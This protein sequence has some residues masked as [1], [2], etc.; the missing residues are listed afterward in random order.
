MYLSIGRILDHNFCSLRHHVERSVQVNVDHSGELIQRV[1][2]VFSRVV[3]SLGDAN[4]SAIHENLEM[5]EF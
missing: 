5:A 3:D 4:S 2:L 1:K